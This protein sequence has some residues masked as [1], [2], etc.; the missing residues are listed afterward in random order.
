MS[1]VIDLTLPIRRHWRYPL[2]TE[3]VESRAKGDFWQVTQVQLKTHWY[4]HID[5]RR[6][7][8]DEGRTLDQYS[9]D[10][11][12]G[13]AVI[14]DL[15]FLQAN[16]A[17]TGDMLE[18]AAQ[19]LQKREM[20]ILRSDWNLKRD[21]DTRAFWADSPYMDESAAVW[22]GEYAPE[23][24]GFDFPQDYCIRYSTGAKPSEGV[25]E[26]ELRYQPCH[27]LL[28]L[29]QDIRMIENMTNL[30]QAPCPYCHIAALPLNLVEADG[31][32]IRVVAFIE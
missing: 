28:L 22:L 17:V 13:E 1:K 27:D 32:P 21:W 31:A 25:P 6:H 23:V 11:L 10:P 5:A 18:K 24:I 9:L 14:L 30:S 3:L 12:V 4:T 29:G 19:G 16:Q 7:I 20:I 8:S 26:E 2:Q 15:G